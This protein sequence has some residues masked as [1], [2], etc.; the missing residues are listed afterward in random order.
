MRGMKVSDISPGGVIA[1][2]LWLVFS[3]LFAL[4]VTNFSSYDKTYGPLALSV[5]GLASLIALYRDA[6]TQTEPAS[7]AAI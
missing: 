6:G 1:T 3:V 4:Y 7:P 5:V 2:L